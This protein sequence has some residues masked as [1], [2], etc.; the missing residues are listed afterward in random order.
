MLFASEEETLHHVSVDKVFDAKFLRQIAEARLHF[1][2]LDVSRS[3][4]TRL[5]FIPVKIATELTASPV[6]LSV[7]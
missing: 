7:L 6:A 2:P 5:L 1:S 4:H 3:T